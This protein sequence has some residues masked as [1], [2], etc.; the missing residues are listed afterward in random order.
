[1]RFLLRMTV[2]CFRLIAIK[3]ISLINILYSPTS[4]IITIPLQTRQYLL[5]RIII[6]NAGIRLQLWHKIKSTPIIISL[7]VL[8]ISNILL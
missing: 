7:R 2:F 3:L 1:M 8:L 5:K 4:Q 6:R